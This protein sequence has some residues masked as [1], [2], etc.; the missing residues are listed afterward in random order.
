[1]LA[2]VTCGLLLGSAASLAAD[3]DEVPVGRLPQDVVPQS[4]AIDLTIVPEKD[5]F[6]GEVRIAVTLA[7]ET[8]HIWLH[9]RDL[10]V[11]L[12]EATPEGGAPIA[13]TYKQVDPSGV[14]RLDLAA[15]LPKGKAVLHF[16]YEA[17]F[18]RQLQALYK[19]EEDGKPYIFSQM[20]PISARLAFPGFDEPGFKAPF[21]VTLT[22]PQE[23]VAISSSPI[24]AQED[25][26]NG[27][28]R[29]RF[30]QTRPLPTYLL[31]VMV[32]DF[33]VVESPALPPNDYRSREVPLRGIAVKG[34]GAE[35]RYALENTGRIVKALE[36]Y[37]GMGFPFPKLDLI[38]VP[39]FAAGAME[40]VGAITFRD[41]IILAGEH[42]S[43]GQLRN[44]RY[45]LAHELAHQWFGDLVTPAW[46]D[47]IWLNESFATWMG[48]RVIHQL[49][50]DE[51]F[52]VG[53]LSYVQEDAFSADARVSARQIRQPVTDQNG[54]NSAFDGITYAKGAGVLAMMEHYVGPYAF[55]AGISQYLFNHKDGTA[56]ADD[57][58]AEIAR[59]AGDPNVAKAFKTFIEQP[60]LPLVETRLACTP[61]DPA[62]GARVTLRQ[63]RYLAL[64]SEAPEPLTWRMPVCLAALADGK[65]QRQCTLLTTETGA[66]DLKTRQCPAA[67]MPNAEGSGYYRW[68]LDEAGWQVLMQNFEGLSPMEQ[69]STADSITA[70]FLSGDL[71]LDRYLDRLE[72]LA[73]AQEWAAVLSPLDTI[74]HLVDQVA[75]P[76]ESPALK[77]RLAGIYAER[78]MALGLDADT[79]ADKTDPVETAR[80]RAQLTGSVALALDYAPLKAAYLARAR[81]YLGYGGDGRI[82]ADAIA[83]DLVRNA[84]DVAA[85]SGNADLIT[86]MLK[87][88]RETQDVT[89][90]A[91]LLHA[92]ARTQAPAL[93]ED[94]RALALYPE[95]R[96]N[97]IETVLWQQMSHV[98][99]RDGMWDWIRGHYDA[100]AGR[101]SK[102]QQPVL[103]SV[104][105]SFC[106]AQRRDEVQ[107]FFKEKVPDMEGGPRTYAQTLEAISG[108]MALRAHNAGS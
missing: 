16:K 66:M 45:V 41:T 35:M 42:P 60:G 72:R 63:S 44:A 107:A 55:K 74:F 2:T 100:L 81:A 87:H 30:A 12:A 10:R 29:V 59:T 39:D 43:R 37:F 51:Q 93:V 106:S 36:D 7:G 23:D 97:E 108:C 40:N 58:Y 61:G 32:G 33:D 103:I 5:T 94:I 46:W 67:L 56:V 4:Y 64:G 84:L 38:A 27:L 101:L 19:V 82:H 3:A 79:P 53:F 95:L 34:K 62:G 1:M 104:T 50:P 24:V 47:D 20:E 11:S 89:L 28:K 70:A 65:W 102:R 71:T 48:N 68:S 31:A 80:A 21:D 77:T 96:G 9:G 76:E 54:I 13:A 90:R 52:D 73:Q 98:E 17:D 91:N 15:P 99:T 22:V 88:F 57:L 69:L 8:D 85:A 92:L 25:A 105:R 83:P 49:W 86:A 6:S 78:A 26:G 75:T 14:V 18:N